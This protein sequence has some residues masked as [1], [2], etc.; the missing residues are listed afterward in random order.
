MDEVTEIKVH[1]LENQAMKKGP[2]NVRMECLLSPIGQRYFGK[3]IYNRLISSDHFIFFCVTFWPD[4]LHH[5]M[6]TTPRGG[7]QDTMYTQPRL[8]VIL[9]CNQVY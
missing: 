8:I 9:N 7:P 4:N 3:L 5:L 2:Q 1:S 6:S